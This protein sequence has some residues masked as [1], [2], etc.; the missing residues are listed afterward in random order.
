MPLITLRPSDARA[1]AP[2]P[3]AVTKGTTP[4]MNAKDVMTIG[5]NL[6]RAALIAASR[7]DSPSTRRRWR[8]TSTMRIAF[9]ALRA[10]SSTSPICV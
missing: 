7:I 5:R 6:M 4:R 1:L 2:A 10:I 8:A 3:V 9:F